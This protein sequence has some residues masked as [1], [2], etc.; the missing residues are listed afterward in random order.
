M[1]LNRSTHIYAWIMSHMKESFVRSSVSTVHAL[2]LRKRN[3]VTREWVMSHIYEWGISYHDLYVYQSCHS[4]RSRISDPLSARYNPWRVPSRR[5]RTILSA[6]PS[7]NHPS[8]VFYFG[9]LHM[10]MSRVKH[11]YTYMGALRN[12]I[13][14]SADPSPNIPSRVFYF[15]CLHVCMSHVTHEYSYMSMCES[16]DT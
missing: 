11:E 8:H 14:L 4:S 9:Y 16:I 13:I 12:R 10:C 6:A 7:S 2:S 15:G 1:C 5:K 3:H